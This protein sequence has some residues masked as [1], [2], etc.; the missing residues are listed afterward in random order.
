MQR[1][2]FAGKG[3]STG[4]IHAPIPCTVWQ[5]VNLRLKASIVTFLKTQKDADTEQE[6]KEGMEGDNRHKQTVLRERVAEGRGQRQG[7][8][9]RGGPFKYTCS[10]AYFSLDVK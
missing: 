9:G 4:G 6:I 8:G 5:L 10:L 2:R 7:T 3:D 1:F